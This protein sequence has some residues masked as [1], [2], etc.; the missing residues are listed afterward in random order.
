MT[1]QEAKKRKRYNLTDGHDILPWLKEHSPSHAFPCFSSHCLNQTVSDVLWRCG[2][3]IILWGK[4]DSH[5]TIRSYGY[6]ECAVSPALTGWCNKE[7]FCANSLRWRW[8]KTENIS[9]KFLFERPPR[10]RG[11]RPIQ[12]TPYVWRQKTHMWLLPCHQFSLGKNNWMFHHNRIIEHTTILFA[13]SWR[14]MPAWIFKRFKKLF[15]L[16]IG[17]GK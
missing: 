7:N 3:Y 11:G 1:C 9:A 6:V 10:R 13:R 2:I 14:M 5:A 15:D 17:S 8:I 4:E 16:F 12:L